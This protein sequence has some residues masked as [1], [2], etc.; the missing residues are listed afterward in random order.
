M[1]GSAFLVGADCGSGR[2]S[3]DLVRDGVI[4]VQYWADGERYGLVLAPVDA[5]FD[6]GCG[7]G[8]RVGYLEPGEARVRRSGGD[9]E[10]VAFVGGDHRGDRIRELLL[11]C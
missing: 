11:C 6:L 5:E 9:V 10:S 2:G 3:A 8:G 7:K 4:G 1:A